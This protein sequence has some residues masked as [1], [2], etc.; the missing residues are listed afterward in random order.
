MSDSRSVPPEDESDLSN[1][2]P[3]SAQLHPTEP[4]R[5]FLVHNWSLNRWLLMIMAGLLLLL[6]VSVLIRT[7]LTSWTAVQI[8]GRAILLRSIPTPLVISTLVFL[9]GVI[10]ITFTIQHW[11]DHLQLTA[12]ALVLQRGRHALRWQWDSISALDT[13]LKRVKFGTGVVSER[14]TIRLRNQD[15]DLLVLR[16]P[17][18]DMPEISRQVREHVIPRLLNTIPWADIRFHPDLSITPAGIRFK[19]R[20]IPWQALERASCVKAHLEIR[21]RGEKKAAARFRLKDISNSDLL[22]TILENRTS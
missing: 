11:K 6:S 21:L 22:L 5:Y 7:L 9:V 15:G 12:H 18:D 16:N 20:E 14:I 4:S 10:L 3:V 17:Y 1:D 19:D 13:H 2:Q 8:H